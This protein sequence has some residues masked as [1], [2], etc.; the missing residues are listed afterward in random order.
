[1]GDLSRNGLSVDEL[2]KWTWYENALRMV[3]NV[4]ERW[5]AR[6]DQTRK[7]DDEE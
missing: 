3:R 1:M 4:G 6:N 5:R 7:I 2:L